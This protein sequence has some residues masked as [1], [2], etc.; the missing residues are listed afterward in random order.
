MKEHTID[1]KDIKYIN[2]HIHEKTLKRAQVKKGD[3]VFAI[4]GTK[5]NLGTVSIIPDNIEEAN[6]NSALVR[7]DL[8]TEIIRKKFFCYLFDFRFVRT[9]INYIGKGVAQNNINNE[10][11]SEILIP[12]P[13]LDVQDKIVIFLDKSLTL[14]K[15][16]IKSAKYKLNFTHLLKKF[17]IYIPLI[18]NKTSIIFHRN[19]L[20]NALNVERYAFTYKIDEPKKWQTIKDIGTVKLNTLTPSDDGNKERDFTLLRIDDLPNKPFKTAIRTVKGSQVEGNLQHIKT[21]DVLVARLAP[22]ITNKKIVI[23]PESNI[24]II[25]SNEFIRLTCN[26][27]NNPVFVCYLLRTEFYTKLMLSKSRGSTPSRYRLSRAD[28]EKLPFP[29]VPKNIQ[30]EIANEYLKNIEEA[31]RLRKEGQEAVEQAKAEVERMILGE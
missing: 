14:R 10:E 30:D 21:N 12:L 9:Q 3:V 15:V 11:I 18:E 1:L 20:E 25:G 2:R 4:S 19:N 8:N 24:P 6:L 26:E 7:L 5:N 16:K 22:T 29:K 27:E 23:A 17:K 13:T 31:L 28:F